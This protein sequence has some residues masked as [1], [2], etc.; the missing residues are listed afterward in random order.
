M[1]YNITQNYNKHLIKLLNFT[2]LSLL[3]AIG[4]AQEKTDNTDK[5]E[6]SQ[7]LYFTAN[8][9]DENSA[10]S[11]KI[12]TEISKASQGDKDATF[13]LL[14]NLTSKDGYPKD[15][16]KRKKVED[17]LKTTLLEPLKDFNGKLIFNPG[18]NEWNKEGQ[19]NIDDM[20]SFL[21][22]NSKAKFWPNDGCASESESLND[23]V[24]LVMVD[25][26]WFLGDWDDYPYIN[27]KCEIKTRD[28]FLIEFKDDLKD[29]QGKT[30]I[31]AVHQPIMSSTKQGFFGIMGGFSPQAYQ[32]QVNDMF[33]GQLETIASEFKDIIFVSGNDRNLQFLE[34]DGIPQIISGTATTDTQKANPQEKKGHFASTKN[35]Y[36]K[37]TVYKDGSSE[38]KFY[39]VSDGG[40]NELFS[41]KIKSERTKLA[42]VTFHKK[43]EFGS[44]FKS[45]VYTKEETDKSAGYKFFWGDHYRDV[46][47]EEIEVPVLFLDTLPGSPRAISEGG[48]HQSR[49]L[50]LIDNDEHEY[51][52]RELRK[53]AVRFIQSTISN[54][55]IEDYMRNTVAESVVQDF[56]TTAHPYAPFAVNGIMETLDIAH[57][58]P[59]VYYIP[60]QQA[61]G[62]FNKDYGDKLYMLEEHVGDENK[63]FKTFGDPDDII[64]T[65]DM[66]LKVQKNKKSYVDEPAY[67]KARLADMMMG[68]WDR[69]YDQWRWAEYEQEDGRKMYKPIPRDRDNAFSKYD[70]LVLK[71]LKL[72]VV[73][74]RFMQSY[75]KDL[76]SVKWFNFEGYPLDKAFIRN[77]DWKVWQDEVAAIQAALTDEKIDE[78]FAEIPE[79]TKDES[80]VKIK[81]ILRKRRDNLQE[82][83][84]QYYD[85]L[86]KYDVVLG[87][88]KDDDFLITRKADGV[89][90]IQISRKDSVV[91]NH[92]YNADLT[93][94]IWIYGLDGDDNFKVTGNG[95]HLIKLKVLGGE[96]HDIYDFE[97]T[98]KVKLY[99]YK[100]KK[101]TIEN[102]ASHKW[103]VDS[104]DINNYN[105]KKRKYSQNV[106][107]PALAFDPDSGLLIGINDTF[108]TYGLAN[109]PF[110]TQHAF[111]AGFYSATRGFSFSYKG[112]FAHVFHNW[113]LGIDAFV[114]S[115]Q[116]TINY[117]GLGNET[118]YDD[119]AV[120]IDYNR[121]SYQYISLAPSLKWSNQR[122]SSFYVKGIAE[123][124]EGEYKQNEVAGEFFTPDDAVFDH[125]YYAGGEVGYQYT[126]K[127]E[128]IAFPRRGM[129][130][131]MVAGYK[132]N[133]DNHDNRFA[134]LKPT[135]SVDY[136]LHRSGMAVL[137]TKIGGE[138]LLGD[139]YEFYH[140]ATVGGNTNIRGYRNNRFTGKSAFYQTTDLR[141]GVAQFRTNFIP[142][143][144]GVSAG[145][146]YGRVWTEDD[147]SKQWHNS[148]G[149]SVFV[150]GFKAITANIGLYHSDEGN[151]LL[152]NLGFSF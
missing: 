15:K 63:S 4:V 85:H 20:E 133:V 132:S 79:D 33:R 130:F 73:D 8:T 98:T 46:Y 31:V 115:P 47:S 67:I 53:S 59:K 42:D 41:K 127:R 24:E 121:M 84:Q 151:R 57:A 54:H 45:S 102:P 105:P 16:D 134:Y 109:N 56:Y 13:V 91:Y 48:G 128:L 30:V 37:L 149:G 92:V 81:E 21:Q 122:G 71:L 96:E 29:N 72:G 147:T 12:L 141:V 140:A 126:T 118:Q 83:A 142:I 124:V 23:D 26:Q 139:N 66:Y 2:L 35:G 68:D 146:D 82:I 97:N 32:N 19:E 80:I 89:T 50:R 150:N 62:I 113:N 100:S 108:T 120:D 34:D 119:D 76:K 152:V 49:S 27:N 22:D 18:V 99:D 52:I 5:K 95:D 55:Y 11:E 111:Q 28:Q 43:N 112:E 69:H 39:E 58:N 138:F 106:I 125:Q 143:R 129:Q 107:M 75:D 38:V 51:T 7:T 136:P 17:Y 137:A 116:Y 86:N 101:N 25:S 123:S 93:K 1:L 103:L 60:K 70:G 14:G 65:A 44:T 87:T 61:L 131:D 135:V 36:A 110:S 9:G 114:T 144:M 78:A 77:S 145:F 3:P 64:S 90:E 40:A 148:Y 88:E 104:Y 74:F 94:E 6:V 117:F 10:V